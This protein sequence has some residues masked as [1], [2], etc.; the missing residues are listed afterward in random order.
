MQQQLNNEFHYTV[1][2]VRLFLG[3][4]IPERRRAHQHSMQMNERVK[5]DPTPSLVSISHNARANSYT[6]SYTE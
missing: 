5:L 6:N 3:K 2:T 4:T 1:K